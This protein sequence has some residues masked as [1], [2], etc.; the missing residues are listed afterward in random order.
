MKESNQRWHNLVLAEF[1]AQMYEELI[2]PSNIISETVKTYEFEDDEGVP[3]NQ[4]MRGYFAMKD[5]DGKNQKYFIP[6]DLRDELPIKVQSTQELLF[7]V[8]SK[9][10]EIIHLPVDTVKFR[11]Y[12]EKKWDN[13]HEFID[14][15]SPF[16]HSNPV[17]WTLCKIMTLV[18][19]VGK[20]FLGICSESEFGKSSTFLMLDAITKEVPV[21]QPRSVPGVLLRINSSGNMVFDEVHKVASDV[22]GC[23]E[24]FS[25]QVAGNSPIYHNGAKQA[26]GLRQSYDVAQQSITF[27]YNIKSQYSDPQNQF[28]D[29]IWVNTK[30]M[31]SRFLRLKLEGRLRERFDNTFDIPKVASNNKMFYVNVAKHLL[32]LRQLKK[33]NGYEL[34]WEHKPCDW[35]GSRH[36]IIYDEIR[37]GIDLYAGSQDEF[38]KLCHELDESIK[39][40]KKMILNVQ[41]GFVPMSEFCEEEKI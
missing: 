8:S 34:R 17:H 23:M 2:Q 32:Y 33:G 15:L 26:K 31:Q 28:W 3:L 41:D 22:K 13:N 29:Y 9:T 6:E 35:L 18:G 38:D 16:E 27:L 30:A 20:T 10:K 1:Q 14:I 40:Y 11:V 5:I 7:K 36:R 39:N 19:F 37:W 12:P 21:Y 25:L 24:N 4:P